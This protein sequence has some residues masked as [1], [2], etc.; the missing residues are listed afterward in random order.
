MQTVEHRLGEPLEVY[1]TRRYHE[2]GL[3]L[4]EVGAEL[5]LSVGTV[6]RWLTALGIEARFPGQ[7]KAAIA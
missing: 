7:R 1:L 5:N 2:D 6:S 3:T 4:R